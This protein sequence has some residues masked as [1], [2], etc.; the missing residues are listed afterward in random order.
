MQRVPTCA[1]RNN[2]YCESGLRALFGAPISSYAQ[3]REV[4]ELTELNA[5]EEG[6]HYDSRV[7]KRASPSTIDVDAR[8]AARIETGA[9]Q[10]FYNSRLYDALK[11][12]PPSRVLDV[13]CGTGFYSTLLAKFGHDVVSIDIS[14]KSIAY[15]RELAIANDCDKS[16]E[17]HVMD[18]SELDFDE[19][20]FDFVTG[21]D[22]IHHLI[23][24]PHAIENMYRVLKPKGKAYFWEPFAFNPI[25]NAMRYV[26]VR[27]RNHEGEHFLREDDVAK[28]ESVFD[29]IEISDKAV[30]YT[31]ARF[32][33]RPGKISKKINVSLKNLDD[34]VQSRFPAL[35]KYYS[36]GFVEMT[37]N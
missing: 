27:V 7:A 26:N 9:Y 21:E 4:Y 18:I 25:I 24:Y 23:K 10:W 31:F 3:F 37:K 19:N 15:A 36:L 5:I 34:R 30:L 14:Q 28:L 12:A 17:H 35:S 13:A 20:S 22:S 29:D 11:N 8:Y 16:I 33:A 32:F 6:A 2:R 1:G